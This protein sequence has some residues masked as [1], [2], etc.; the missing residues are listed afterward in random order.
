MNFKP[1]ARRALSNKE[2]EETVGR[3]M[4]AASAGSNNFHKLTIRR[5]FKTM[6]YKT[7]AQLV[8]II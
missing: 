8:Q 2:R 5:G 7:K 6:N 1:E 4:H 3:E